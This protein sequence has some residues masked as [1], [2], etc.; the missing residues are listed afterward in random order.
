MQNFVEL[1]VYLSATP[2]FGLTA[3][4]VTYVL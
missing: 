1:W 4:I 3:T 2:L